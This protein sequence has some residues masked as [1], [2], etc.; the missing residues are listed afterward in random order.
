MPEQKHRMV[1][2]TAHLRFVERE[3]KRILQQRWQVTTYYEPAH[4]PADIH[5]EW[6][7]VPLR[8]E[9]EQDDHNE[10]E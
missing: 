9:D 5:R 6:R 7:D 2:P 4:T 3:G 1:T 10:G 8:P